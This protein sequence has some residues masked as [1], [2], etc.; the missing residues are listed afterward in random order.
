M[1]TVPLVHELP[2]PGVPAVDLALVHLVAA[3]LRHPPPV[4]TI[5]DAQRLLRAALCTRTLRHSDITRTKCCE[6][7]TWSC[8]FADTRTQ[9]GLLCP[10]KETRKSPRTA[11]GLCAFGA[12][13][14]KKARPHLVGAE[15]ALHFLLEADLPVGPAQHP[16]PAG[17]REKK[18]DEKDARHVLSMKE[19]CSGSCACMHRARA[20]ARSCIGMNHACVCGCSTHASTVR[21]S[22]EPSTLQGLEQK[23]ARQY[24]MAVQNGAL[25]SSTWYGSGGTRCASGTCPRGTGTAS[26]C[27]SAGA[28][29]NAASVPL[30]PTRSLLHIQHDGT[31]QRRALPTSTTALYWGGSRLVPGGG[32]SSARCGTSSATRAPRTCAAP[33]RPSACAR[34]G[35]GTSSHAPGKRKKKE[36]EREKKKERQRLARKRTRQA[37]ERDQPRRDKTRRS[38]IRQ[39]QVG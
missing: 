21:S 33:C 1:C 13:A 31:V 24:N 39:A 26:S 38:K 35:G 4:S 2:A 5:A 27:S 25:G 14:A 19:T 7:D 3:L 34:C 32:R 16:R 28:V 23:E 20:C 8:R 9:R 22:I 15:A 37:K 12:A 18:E 30:L 11:L 17:E 6:N 36:R 10:R 29:Q